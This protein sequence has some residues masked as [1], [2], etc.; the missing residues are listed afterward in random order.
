MKFQGLIE[1]FA[2]GPQLLRDAVQGM[3]REQVLARPVPGKWS[4]LEVVCHLSDFE[5]VYADRIKRIIAEDRPL[6][7]DGD[8]NLFAARLAYHSRDLAEELRVID[9]IHTQLARLLRLQNDADFARVGNHATAGPLTMEQFVE[10]V[11]NHF[12]HHIGFIYEK[13]TALGMA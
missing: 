11:A 9:S 2:T 3:S 6:L 12:D 13:R 10:R 8:E 4:T 1:R 7:P 5:I